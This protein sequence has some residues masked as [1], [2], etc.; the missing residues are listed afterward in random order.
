[1]LKGFRN[2]TFGSTPGSPNTIARGSR[3]FTREQMAPAATRKPGRP[4]LIRRP[5]IKTRLKLDLPQ[6]IA[7][8]VTRVDSSPLTGNAGTMG[9]RGAAAKGENA[10]AGEGVSGGR[11]AGGEDGVK[12]PGCEYR[13]AHGCSSV[14][15]IYSARRQR[16][17]FHP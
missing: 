5:S 13:P 16:A 1:M 7:P 8:A 11:G 14:F 2:D 9:A 4:L 3:N 10:E 17:D 6:M 15:G 12:A